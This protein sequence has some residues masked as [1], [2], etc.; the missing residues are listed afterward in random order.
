MGF[1]TLP[2]LFQVAD[3]KAPGSPVAKIYL[4]QTDPISTVGFQ[5]DQMVMNTVSGDVFQ[6]QA[7]GWQKVTNLRGPAG[8]NGDGHLDP[9]E[10]AALVDQLDDEIE[11]DIDPVLLFENALL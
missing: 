3:G 8:E 5:R 1:P 2:P 11:S 4:S 9:I 7:T 10:L 6:L